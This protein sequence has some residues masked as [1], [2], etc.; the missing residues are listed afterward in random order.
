MIK[1]VYEKHRAKKKSKSEK[2]DSLSDKLEK[3]NE[4]MS[5]V[6]EKQKYISRLQESDDDEFERL[7]KNKYKGISHSPPIVKKKFEHKIKS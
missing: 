3:L 6:Q 7:V 1:G 4:K 5:R 2:K